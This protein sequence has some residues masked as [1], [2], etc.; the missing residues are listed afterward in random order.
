MSAEITTAYPVWY[1]LNGRDTY[2]L[3]IPGDPDRLML[4]DGGRL[5]VFRN[6]EEVEEFALS[7]GLKIDRGDT[8][9]FDLDRIAVWLNKPNATTIECS[10]F[11]DAWNL[12]EDVMRTTATVPKRTDGIAGDDVL[13]NKLFW[14]IN[15][16][17]VTPTGERFN[18]TWT[19]DEVNAL[20]SILGTGLE[21]FRR[22]TILDSDESPMSL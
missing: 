17:A 5:A 9:L 12:F 7:Q 20:K 15:L 22:A 2:L 3:M 11:L 14:G 4:T 10:N 19:S 18:P 21:V 8:S 16:P 6:L 13:Y 1:R